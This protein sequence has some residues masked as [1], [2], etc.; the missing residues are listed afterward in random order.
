MSGTWANSA[1]F[2]DSD[3]PPAEAPAGFQGV[4]S[5]SQWKGVI[6]F[7]QAVNAKLVTSFA[8]SA[9]VRNAAG[10]WTPVQA[11]PLLQY[12]QSIGGKVAAA[13]LFQRAVHALRWWRPPGI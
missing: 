1:Y 4:L 3:S 7:S 8:I 2:S 11:R 12:T 6:D 9:G 5:R 10:V 13:E